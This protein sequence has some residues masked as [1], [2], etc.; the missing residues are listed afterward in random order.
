[1][2]FNAA[3]SPS[4]MARPVC[5]ANVQDAP[6]GVGAFLAPIWITIALMVKCDAGGFYQ[7]LLQQE[8]AFLGQDARG[9]WQ[10][11]ACPGRQDILHQQVGAIV[12]AAPNNTALGVA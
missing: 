5:V 7:D 6:A 4:M 10:G 3:T 8:R 1:M 12:R 2:R 11:S 9:F